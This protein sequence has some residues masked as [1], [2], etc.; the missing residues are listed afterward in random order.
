MGKGSDWKPA[1]KE[2]LNLIREMKNARAFYSGLAL[3]EILLNRFV[4]WLKFLSS[5][6]YV[7][8]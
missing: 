1:L 4:T 8:E 2:W 7:F 6:I 3:K 5:S